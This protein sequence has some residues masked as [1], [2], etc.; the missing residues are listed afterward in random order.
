MRGP[1]GAGN[2]FTHPG[3]VAI[4]RPHMRSVIGGL[5]LAL[6]VARPALA[7]SILYA[8]A[9]SQQRIDGFCLGA[10]GALAATPTVQIGTG[11]RFPRRVLVGKDSIGNGVVLYVAEVDRIEAFRI[12]E[13]GVLHALGDTV[14]V[15]H[16][17]PRDLA[18]SPDGKTLYV[19]HQG[20]LEAFALGAGGSLPKRFT[21]CVQAANASS[22]LDAQATAGLL[23]VSA[24][25]IP[26]RI[27]IYRLNADGSLPDMGCTSNASKKNRPA[28]RQWDSARR[29]LQKPKAFVV[30]GDMIYVEERA[31]RRITA[32]RLQPDGTF[33]DAK[34]KDADGN[35]V[36]PE[37]CGDLT[38]FLPTKRCERRQEK[39]QRQQCAASRTASVLQYESLILAP[40]GDALLGTQYFKGRLDA[41]RLRTDSRLPG[42]PAVKLPQQP[43][44]M[45]DKN[46]V[47]TPVRLTATTKAVYVAGGE[48]DR[49]AAFH[50][51][52]NGVP[53]G[54]G[55]FSR[56]DE[57][58]NSFPNDVGVAVL[59]GSCE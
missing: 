15:K 13:H 50:L 7:G 43:T 34:H 35:P 31:R 42:D 58:T 19:T 25:D 14:P 32:F 26:G 47:M 52:A 56:T 8:T 24:D 23:Y 1:H 49:V 10:D 20:F 54:Q 12:G 17:D 27:A 59:S 21:S 16:L 11:G 57:Q 38:Y 48:L 44:F 6:V 36:A 22:F 5:L 9:A 40:S 46:P 28:F 3:A 51:N 45:S 33:C 55:P 53:D 39:K 37:S 18:L 4:S 41:Y 2:R 30:V 29:R